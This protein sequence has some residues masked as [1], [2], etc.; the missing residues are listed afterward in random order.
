L[1]THFAKYLN[2]KDCELDVDVKLHKYLLTF[3]TCPS[4]Y[5]VEPRTSRNYSLVLD[6]D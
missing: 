1:L 3:M 2:S 4:P 6:L 5:I